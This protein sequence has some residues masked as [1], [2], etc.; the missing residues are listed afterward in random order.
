M[1][2]RAIVCCTL[3]SGTDASPKEHCMIEMDVRI[4]AG[5]LYDF[6]LKHSYSRPATYLSSAVGA[7]G[8]IYGLATGYY[9][10]LIV[11]AILLLYL[12]V[13][14]FL[15]S[16]QTVALSPVFREPLHYVLDDNGLTVS[17]GENSTFVPWD[18][19]IR[20]TSTGRGIFLYTGPA[21]ATIFPRSQMGDKTTPVIQ[22]IHTHMDPKK[23]KIRT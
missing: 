3:F 18:G 2:I 7:V 13:H 19:V 22:M 15:Q 16:K 12:P 20:A 1:F 14:L 4:T 11:G 17:Q 8:V 21:N 10:L 23:V 6:N 9:L 5:D